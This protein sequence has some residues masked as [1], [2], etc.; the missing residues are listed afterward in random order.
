MRPILPLEPA[1]QNV[2]VEGPLGGAEEVPD[3][4]PE[5]EPVPEPVAP[6]V[7]SDPPEVPPP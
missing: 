5:V 7:E 1:G 4:E 2:K 3:P 6:P